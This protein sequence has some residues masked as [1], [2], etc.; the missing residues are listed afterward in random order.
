MLVRV[1]AQNW[2]LYGS[3]LG[4]AEILH[5]MLDRDILVLGLTDG[6]MV[7]STVIGLLLQKAV[8]HEWISWRRT[9]WIIQN[10]WQTFYLFA[11]LAWNS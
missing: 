9:G 4:K 5:I 2:K 10:V 6:V 11:I 8:Q 3:V 1:A 7:G